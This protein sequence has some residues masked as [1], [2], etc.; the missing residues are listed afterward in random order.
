MTGLD[1]AP[2]NVVVIGASAAGLAVV[3][4]LRRDGYD[5]RLTLVGTEVHPPYDRPPL[6]KQVL[7]GKWPPERVQ[8]RPPAD[9]AGLDLDLRLGVAATGLDTGARQVA[10]SAGGP[11]PYD[12]LVIAT[13]VT[14]RRLP[15]T[16]QLRGIHTLRTLDDALG[17]AAELEPGR[18][19]AVVGGGFLG[20][21]VAAV[22]AERGVQVT[23][24]EPA[25]TLLAVAVGLSIGAFVA[26]VHRAH[27]VDV[28]TGEGSAVVSVESDDGA[29]TGLRLADG[30]RI[31]TD[32]VL[33]A[34]GSV[35]SVDWLAGSG[36]RC[37]DGVRCDPSCAAAPGVYAAG[38][39]ARWL[40]PR[41][42]A[43]MRIEHRTNA[44]EQGVHVARVLTT[45]EPEPF[46]P[47]P[48]FWSD[49]YDLKIQ[50][51]GWLR[52]HDEMRVI[53]E[54]PDHGRVVAVYR[55]GD[56]LVGVLGVNSARAIRRWRVALTERTD[57]H[58]AIAA[59]LP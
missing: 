42:G 13:G 53:E 31:A 38:D 29:V 32:A 24:L 14:P 5:G 30:S 1:G 17:L 12:R 47:V 46:A 49:Q 23:L 36:L 39:V 19:L 3:E 33:V 50:S 48:Y 9:L 34:I 55:K 37:D 52:G 25:P 6:S 58:D 10:L 15:G 45:G 28:R 43:E 56:R 27:G 7:S 35:P 21:E 16:G 40:N 8:L 4:A 22:A 44:S 51:F 26:D 59:A 20:S 41:F 11:L 57:W 2:H 18:R 54:D